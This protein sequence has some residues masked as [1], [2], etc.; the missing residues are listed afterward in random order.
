MGI[1]LYWKWL[2]LVVLIT[3]SGCATSISQDHAISGKYF[4]VGVDGNDRAEGTSPA[5]AI[6]TIQK[7]LKKARPGDTVVLL[8]GIYYQDFQSVRAGTQSAPIRIVGRPGTIVKGGGKAYIIS[9]RH[10]FIELHN[11]TIDGLIDNG[12]GEKPDYRK[13]LVYIKGLKGIGIRGV[14]LLD[15]ELKNAEDECLRM[16]YQAQ[17]NEIAHSWIANCGLRDFSLGDGG[18]NGEAI[19]IGTAP[20]Q[21]AEGVNPGRE[22]DH[23]DRNWIHHNVIHSQGSECVDIKEGSRYNLVEYNL[24]T[25][26]KDANVAGISIRGNKNTIRYN[27]VYDNVG[28]GIRLGGDT[29]SDGLD[30]EVYG[31]YL[32]NNKN[33]A[34]KITRLPQRKIC[35][36]TII[37]NKNQKAV[38]LSEKADPKQFLQP[39]S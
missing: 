26:Q 22:I 10:S 39:C 37:L 14:R 16:K 25:Q 18:H 5:R 17:Q 8:P 33:G 28:A 36:N 19:Y 7:A 13:K 30:N 15:M 9:L 35:G 3:A 34:L 4:F 29:P 6:R 27:Q 11:F 23:S 20:E 32:F 38:R 2:I 1:M 12:E 31:N 21:I 24:C